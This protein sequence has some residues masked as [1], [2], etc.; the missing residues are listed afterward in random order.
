MTARSEPAATV[1]P[2]PHGFTPTLTWRGGFWLAL[3]I[4]MSG[5]TLI[6]YEVGAVGAWGALAIWLGTSVIALL[7]NFIY[8]ELAGMHPGASGGIA[9]YASRI[10]S[11]YFA[12]L[13]GILGW[14]YWA[15]WSLT[16]AVVRGR[17]FW[18]E[19]PRAAQA[20]TGT[21]HAGN[22]AVDGVQ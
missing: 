22:Q 21:A 1:Q 15:G 8:A 2:K 20:S 5:L 14:S 11:R 3:V 19:A 17:A 13:G 10:W 18:R 4:P 12:P 16:L 7:Q 9:I 6:G